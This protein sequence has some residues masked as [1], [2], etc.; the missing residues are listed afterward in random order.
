MGIYSRFGNRAGLLEAVYQRGFAM[1]RDRLVAAK[2]ADG[3]GELPPLIDAYRQHALDNPALYGLMFER[4]LPDFEPGSEARTQALGMTF[5]VLQEAVAARLGTGADEAARAAY[6]IWTALHGMVSIELDHAVRAPLEGWFLATP[7]DYRA[8]THEG[9]SAL[10][11]ALE[12]TPA[13]G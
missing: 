9:L 12:S 4:P 13:S 8:I 2:P 5:S 7:D 10:I 3:P 11:G 6:L 1:L